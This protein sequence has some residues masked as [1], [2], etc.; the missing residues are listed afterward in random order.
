MEINDNYQKTR[1]GTILNRDVLS[2][3][4]QDDSTTITI[5]GISPMEFADQDGNF[6]Y[7]EG[8][9]MVDGA[10]CE[11]LVPATPR[12]IKFEK[13]TRAGHLRPLYITA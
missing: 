6:W 13:W 2:D 12:E 7:L 9:V 10:E 5:V 4:F 3:E 11:A 8:D 1:L